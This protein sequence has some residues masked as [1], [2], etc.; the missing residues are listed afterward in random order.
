MREGSDKPPVAR[1]R[2]AGAMVKGMMIWSL[3]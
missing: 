3:H 1:L 2:S